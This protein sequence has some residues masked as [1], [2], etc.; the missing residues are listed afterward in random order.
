MPPMIVAPDRDV[1]GINANACAQP[2][3][4]ASVQRMASTSSI[5]TVDGARRRRR[6]THRMTSAPMM[7]ASATG[8]GAKR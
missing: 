4:S 7:N 2:I 5:R 8:T 1:P 6:S 3:F